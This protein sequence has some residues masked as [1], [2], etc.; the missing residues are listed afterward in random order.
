MA[1]TGSAPD[2]HEFMIALVRRYRSLRSYQ[3]RATTTFRSITRRPDGSDEVVTRRQECR[4][5]F[6]A[7][8]R[9]VIPSLSISLYSDGSH[10]WRYHAELGQYIEE[11]ID[12]T[13]GTLSELTPSFEQPFGIHPLAILLME[14]KGPP[15][16]NLIEGLSGLRPEVRDGCAGHRIEGLLNVPWK[17]TPATMWIEQETGLLREIELDVTRALD[18]VS[19]RTTL[20]FDDVCI[21]A[22]IEQQRFVFRPP[23]GARRV[24]V[25]EEPQKEA[26]VGAQPAESEDA[27]ADSAP[28]LTVPLTEYAAERLIAGPTQEMPGA[29]GYRPR[30]ADVDGDGLAEL[31]LLG[32]QHRGLYLL[33][34][35]RGDVQQVA[36]HGVSGECAG[37][38]DAE[39]V[40]LDGQRHWFVLLGSG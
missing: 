8:N 4:L 5:T 38:Y 23:S 33:H 6:A 12:E 26:Q 14:T 10:F 17:D 7:P 11:W 22:A 32:T 31:I 25:F 28:M 3:D 16:F 21:D 30:Q 37:I 34:P 40:W 13:Y 15:W 20:R 27:S 24:T 39:P 18:A 19:A 36:L 29:L 2:A 9:I 1:G 35:E